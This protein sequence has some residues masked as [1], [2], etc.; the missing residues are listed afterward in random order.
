MLEPNAPAGPPNGDNPGDS[1]PG[2][3]FDYKRAYEAL[4]PEYTR[5][6]QELSQAQAA[7]QAAAEY[8][9]LFAA[10]QDPDQQAE[11]L[12]AL[13]FD[14]DTGAPAGSQADPNAFVD[15]LEQEVETLRSQLDEL[16]Q[17]QQ[18]V[19]TR[20]EQEQLIEMRDQ[21]IGDALSFIE[22]QTSQ[23][24]TAREEEVLGNLAVALE[25]EEGVPDVQG[26]YEAIYGEQ[27]V[28]ELRRQSWIES[29]QRASAP[30]LGTSIPADRR[31]ATRQDRVAY[32]DERLR[33][34]GE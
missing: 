32:I 22:E 26:A 13:G 1:G 14:M 21:Y 20:R 17:S 2:Q 5:T 8:E 29:K 25:T 10:L 6:T 31:P 7:A 28:L 30:P 9:Q 27:G 19:S 34:L 3:E 23:K 24:F 33:T 11:A 12:A 4:R 15:P 18:E 16:R